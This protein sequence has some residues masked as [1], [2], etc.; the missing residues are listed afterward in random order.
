MYDPGVRQDQNSV[1]GQ[2]HAT[3]E[4]L[5]FLFFDFDLMPDV[6]VTGNLAVL[7]AASINGTAQTVHFFFF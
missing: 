1:T 4:D 7:L 3:A 6:S 2:L 5:E